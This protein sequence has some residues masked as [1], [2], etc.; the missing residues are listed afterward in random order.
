M[1]YASLSLCSS[2]SKHNTAVKKH[3]IDEVVTAQVGKYAKE[4]ILTGC[5]S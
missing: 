5:C 4:V 2:K 1:K 3:I